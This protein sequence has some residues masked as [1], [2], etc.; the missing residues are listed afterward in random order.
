MRY[1]LMYNE[2]SKTLTIEDEDTDIKDNIA[3]KSK[4]VSS[5]VYDR[6]GEVP[7]AASHPQARQHLDNVSRTLAVDPREMTIKNKTKNERLD[8]LEREGADP[9][10]GSFT[11]EGAMPAATKAAQAPA[12]EV[13]DFAEDPPKKGTT[14][15]SR[16]AARAKAVE[17]PADR[18]AAKTN[19]T[20]NTAPSPSPTA[21]AVPVRANNQP[22]PGR[23]A[24]TPAPT[25]AKA[26]TKVDA[27]V[28]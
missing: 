11:D 28:R 27:K 8:V 17:T 16:A 14:D 2:K 26:T 19:N 24:A 1:A 22:G 23:P 5:L 12:N 4:S 15:E 20:A 10:E 13:Q 25:P 18:A 7:D 9:V 6:F 3:S 21:T